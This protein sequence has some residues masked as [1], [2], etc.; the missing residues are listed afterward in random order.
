LTF[1]LTLEYCLLLTPGKRLHQVWFFYTF[2]VFELEDRTGE[3]DRRTAR[4]ITWPTGWP[5]NK[6]KQ[7][8]LAISANFLRTTQPSIPPGRQMS[9][10]NACLAGFTCV[11]RQVTLCINVTMKHCYLVVQIGESTVGLMKQAWTLVRR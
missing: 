7:L 5:H 6:V 8:L 4:R 2:F 11:G 9:T 10:G 3:T 1:E